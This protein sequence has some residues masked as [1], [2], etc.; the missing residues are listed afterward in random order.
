MG[1]AG[2]KGAQG[3]PGP[4]GPV[5]P[6]G[7]PGVGSVGLYDGN[8]VRIGGV[9]GI[10]DTSPIVAINAFPLPFVLRVNQTGFETATPRAG[11]VWFESMDCGGTPYVSGDL[12][13]VIPVV[14]VRGPNQIA[15]VADPLG[16][17]FDIIARS[18]ID[19]SAPCRTLSV[20]EL[21]NDAVRALASASL[22]QYIPPFTVR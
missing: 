10:V 8:G 17:S 22:R 15:Y 3:V 7:P 6:Q 9:V 19:G 2:Q 21:V 20:P 1:P 4:E 14:V 18:T 11:G 12:N 13:G 5:G 16:P